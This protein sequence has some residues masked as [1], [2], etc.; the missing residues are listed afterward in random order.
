[1]EKSDNDDKKR[2]HSELKDE[3]KE[4]NIQEYV[5]NLNPSEEAFVSSQ[6]IESNNG[7][8]EKDDMVVISEPEPELIEGNMISIITSHGGIMCEYNNDS[9]DI[10]PVLFE[11]P[12]GIE[13]IKFTISV[14]GIVSA[15]DETEINIIIKVINYYANYLISSNFSDVYLSLIIK[16]IQKIFSKKQLM[17]YI[18]YYKD[19]EATKSIHHHYEKGFKI[20]KLKPGDKIIDKV[21][22]RQLDEKTINDF[23]I[24]EL[25][26]K[27]N[28]DE[29]EESLPDLFDI[30][31]PPQTAA[32]LSSYGFS[33]VITT[34]Q[35][36]KYYKSKGIKKLL[37]FDF[38][39][40]TFRI[41]HKDINDER[42]ERRVRRNIDTAYGGS[43]R[44]KRKTKKRKIK[45][46]KTKTKRRD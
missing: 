1:M 44:R 16:E 10:N 12:A 30:Y 7:S 36:I 39:C 40:S 28:V 15:S 22:T 2:R 45:K 33:Q 17:N 8:E 35:M 43:K 4:Q 34:K 18:S 38:S 32:M 9:Y 41:D 42:I 26:H 24:L 13:I 11:I 46:R 37:I 3:E 20:Y 25:S 23:S 21:F 27:Y 6:E 19:D 5:I 31:R 14:P 29:L